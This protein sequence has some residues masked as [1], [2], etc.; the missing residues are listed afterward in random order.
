MLPTRVGMVRRTSGGRSGA[1]GAPHPRGDGPGNTARRPLSEL[2]SP[3]A[4]GWSDRTG[5]GRAPEVVL[6]T[7]V[8]MVRVAATCGLAKLGAPH[9]RGD[10][11]GYSAGYKAGRKCSPPAWGWSA[12]PDHLRLPRDVLPT[13]V[14][15]VRRSTAQ[16]RSS[17]S[18]PH[19]RGDGPGSSSL[20]RR[21]RLCSPPAWGWS[22]VTFTSPRVEWVLPTRVGMVRNR[23]HIRTFRLGAPHPRGDGPRANK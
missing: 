17:L 18:A 21:Q 7:R 6:P 2:C 11:P 12:V 15:M 3:P 20:C 14:G 1:T 13:R 4:W 9:P 8:G 19:P 10:G 16:P 22:E 23:I 5:G